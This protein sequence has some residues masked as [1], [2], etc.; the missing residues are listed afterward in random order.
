MIVSKALAFLAT[1][2]LY[3]F[4]KNKVLALPSYAEANRNERKQIILHEK[5]MKVYLEAQ[6]KFL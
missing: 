2:N 1:E 5:A 6:Q 3:Q 4:H